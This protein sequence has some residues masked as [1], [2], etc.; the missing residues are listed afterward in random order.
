[1]QRLFFL[2]LETVGSLSTIASLASKVAGNVSSAKKGVD[3][4]FVSYVAYVPLWA[5]VCLA[6]SPCAFTCCT[7]PCGS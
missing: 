1:M 6:A 2:S 4:S 7:F 3:A 5:V